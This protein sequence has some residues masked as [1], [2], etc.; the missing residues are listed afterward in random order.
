MQ[1]GVASSAHR[2]LGDPD[3]AAAAAVADVCADT[4][5]ARFLD[6]LLIEESRRVHFP[7]HMYAMCMCYYTICYCEKMIRYIVSVYSERETAAIQGA[8]L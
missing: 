1:V 4:A 6:F 3:A 8:I 2:I 5:T 7:R